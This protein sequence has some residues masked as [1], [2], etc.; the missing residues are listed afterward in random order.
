MKVIADCDHHWLIQSADKTKAKYL[1]GICKFCGKAKQFNRKGKFKP[2][3]QKEYR[4]MKRL[5]EEEEWLD[6]IAPRY[7]DAEEVVLESRRQAH[8][9]YMQRRRPATEEE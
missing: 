5:I 8:N 2:P 4:L 9:W 7:P 6:S 1:L 3:S